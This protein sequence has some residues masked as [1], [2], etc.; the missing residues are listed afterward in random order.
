MGVSV[1]GT[2]VGAG[3]SVGLGVGTAVGSGVGAGDGVT[4]AGVGVAGAGV[5]VAG[6]GVGVAGAG[7]GVAGAAVQLLVV[8]AHALQFRLYSVAVHFTVQVHTAFLN[9]ANTVMPSLGASPGIEKD[10]YGLVTSLMRPTVQPQPANS[11]PKA[12]TACT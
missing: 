11:Y 9:F 7:E 12:G 4:G 2:S 6:A 10:K 1:G 5:G 8:A 3:T